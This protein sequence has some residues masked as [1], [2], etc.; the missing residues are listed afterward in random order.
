VT[1]AALVGVKLGLRQARLGAGARS[2]DPHEPAETDRAI[3]DRLCDLLLCD[4][5]AARAN[6]ERE[7]LAGRARVVGDIRVD[8]DPAAAAISAWLEPVAP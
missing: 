4:D 7:G 5:D 6:L 2:G 3:V 8:P 1:A